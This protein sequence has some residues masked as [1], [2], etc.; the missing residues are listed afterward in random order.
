MAINKFISLTYLKKMIIYN[1]ILFIKFE[2]ES[3]KLYIA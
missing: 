1:N 2:N 3:N